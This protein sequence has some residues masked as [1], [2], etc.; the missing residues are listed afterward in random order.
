MELGV[1]GSVWYYKGENL[2]IENRQSTN[3]ANRFA[4][5]ASRFVNYGTII[6]SAATSATATGATGLIVYGTTLTGGGGAGTSAQIANMYN[7]GTIRA[8]SR[9][10]VALGTSNTA[11]GLPNIVN[12]GR[13][14]GQIQLRDTTASTTSITNSGIITGG[15]DVYT[16][17]KTLIIDNTG[18]IDLIDNTYMSWRVH[19]MSQ[20]TVQIKNY[21]MTINQNQ[22]EFNAFSGYASGASDGSHLVIYDTAKVSFY[23]TNSKI[24]LRFGDNFEFNKA[25]ALNK[26]ITN[27]GGTQHFIAQPN[28]TTTITN[29]NLFHYLTPVSSIYELSYSPDNGGSFVVS[30]NVEQKSAVVLNTKQNLAAMNAFL[31]N[32]N[33]LLYKG[34]FKKKFTKKKKTTKSKAQKAQLPSEIHKEIL[35]IED[36]EFYPNGKFSNEIHYAK[37]PKLIQGFFNNGAVV[38]AP[39]VSMDSS[40]DGLKMSG[41]SFG[42]IGVYRKDLD[43]KQSFGVQL[44]ASM[45]EYND[46]NND[47][48]TLKNTNLTLGAHYKRD[49]RGVFKQKFL[50]DLYLTARV[51]GFYFLNQ[52]N[53]YFV[54]MKPNNY[55]IALGADL[56]KDFKLKFDEWNLGDVGVLAGLDVRLFQQNEI[57]VDNALA[58]NAQE[59]YEKTLLK[60]LFIDLGAK[61]AKSLPY[62]LNFDASLGIKYNFLGE[63]KSNVILN[64]VSYEYGIS[65]KSYTYAG[66]GLA[67]AYRKSINLALRYNGNFGTNST[68]HSGFAEV[69]YRW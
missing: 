31:Q 28:T 23:D 58:S 36:D 33:A 55:A 13:I 49:L 52:I 32:S 44:G 7:Y 29:A 20:G 48:L 47:T 4:G 37:V 17:N 5:T 61:Y 62:K 18:T 35:G 22:S 50:K 24:I 51:D 42:F 3:I 56:N 68:Q 66:L 57:S 19:I 43:A 64:N 16:A 10:T 67:Y 2:D 34:E 59:N 46:Q 26:L 12:T 60:M 41:T 25:Y 27:Y 69:E 6:G 40:E 1:S 8:T 38:F 65:E 39:F 54:S 30:M 14:E 15:I 45:G 53:S 63:N 11:N 21:A 9:S